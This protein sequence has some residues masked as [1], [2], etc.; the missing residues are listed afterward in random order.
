M[1]WDDAPPDPK[2]LQAKPAQAGSW[3]AEP[4]KPEELGQESFGHKALGL[5][6]AAAKGIDSVTGA[7]VRAAIGA[8]QNAN[9]PGDIPG[10]AWKAAKSQF[11]DMTH[12]APTGKDIAMKA[13]LSG[14][15]FPVYGKGGRAPVGLSTAG[16]AGAGIDLAANPLNLAGPAGRVLGKGAEAVGDIAGPIAG[17]LEAFAHEKAIKA[18]GAMTKDFRIIQDKGTADALGSF[19]LDHKLVTPLSTVSKVAENIQ[20]AKQTAGQTIGHILDTADAGNHIKIR[21]GDIALHLS[22]DPEISALANIPGKEGTSKQ[23]RNFLSTLHRNGNEL[24][25]RDAQ[26][27]RQGIDDSINFN[28]RVP[29]MAGAQPYLYKMRDALS[30]AMNDSIN[31]LDSTEASIAMPGPGEQAMLPPSPTTANGANRLKEANA[32]YSKLAQ[33]DKIAQNRVGAIQSNRGVSLT[34]TIAGA[35]GA[36][37]GH[38]H[39]PGT[40]ATLG[41][42]AALANKAGR[43]FG[44][45]VMATGAN[46]AAKAVKAAPGLI[47]KVPGGL[48]PAAG[49][50][51]EML[52]GPS[53]LL[54]VRG[55]AQEKKK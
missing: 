36:A 30:T 22:E 27:L 48:L 19:L 46:A 11:G 9:T 50:G 49:A 35:A 52:K 18:A 29:E 24:S 3:D 39:S 32:A 28:K 26:K 13:G 53:G 8:A 38:G 15:E 33:L 47:G 45:P 10:D 25:L 43:T 12:E 54:P 1:G 51:A 41:V 44:N 42:G 16:I 2:E 23:V 6:G 40:I 7:P 55:V 37:L 20:A 17:K 34:D 21:A 4:P 14:E 31:A 5:L